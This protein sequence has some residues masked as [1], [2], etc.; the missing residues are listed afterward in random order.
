MKY[1][2]P[3]T[4]TARRGAFFTM[5]NEDAGRAIYTEAF[6]MRA[7]HKHG[8]FILILA[9]LFLLLGV[10]GALAENGQVSGIVWQDKT[11][12]GVIAGGETGL[13][14]AKVTLEI[15]DANG[16]PQV[17]VNATS[18]KSG[19]F[20]FT[21]LGAGEYRLR[22]E[23][24]KD[25]HFTL[26]GLDSAMLPA[27]GNVSYSPWFTLGENESRQMN[28]GAT[29]SS[30][31]VNLI[32]FEDENANG[33]RMQ[34]EPLLKGV[35]TEVL[36]E[37]QDETCL[38][39]SA[40]TDR[41]GQALIRDLSPGTYRVRVTFPDHF[42]AGPIGQKLN[43]FYNCILPSEDNATGLSEPFTLSV[44]ESMSMGA[45]MVRTGSLA[46]RAWF[47]ANFNGRW[48]GDESG[49][50]GAQVVLHAVESGFQRTAQ[51]D[52]KGDFL[53]Q[54][55]QPGDYL[56]QFLLPEGMIFTYP[57]QSL[58]SETAG[59]GTVNV[60]V[61]V[62]VTT[63]LGAVGAMD[64]AGLTLTLYG[65]LNLNGLRDPD[66]PALSG[67]AVTA[68]QG[69][70]IVE[71]AVTDENGA[72][73]F[74]ALR[75]GDTQ[76]EAAL[77]EG[78]LFRADEGGLFSVSGVQ[79]TAQAAVA[80]D[81]A[82]PDAQFEA[83]VIPAAAV[84]G[85]LFEDAVN[86][87]LFREDSRLLSGFTVQAV[88]QSG[89]V[90][91]EAVTDENGVYTLYPLP[92]DAY[93]VRFLLR[94]AYVASPFAADQE[95]DGNQI[96]VQTPAYGETAAFTLA[97]GEQK[98]GV[99]G[100]VFQA[101]LAEGYVLVDDAYADAGPGLSGVK[102]TLLSADG[103]PASDHSYG[104]TDENGYFFIKG[105]LPGTYS[106]AYQLPENGV[107]TDPAVKGT[108]YTGEAFQSESGS[109]IE[110]PA[111]KGMYTASVS[112]AI[113]HSAPEEA[114]LFTAL[115]T[116]RGH[117]VNQ[118][119]EIHANPDGS[120]A[121]SGLLPDTYT[122]TATLPQ[123]LAFGELEGSPFGRS[124]NRQQSAEITLAMGESREDICIQAVTPLSIFG[125]LYYDDDFSGLQDEEE[126]GAENRAVSLWENGEQIDACE[127]DES[128]GFFF[129]QVIPGTYEVR[130]VMDENEELEDIPDAIR[131]AGE[132]VLPI[133]IIR[134][135]SL[136][137]PVMRYASV[138]GQVWSLGSGEGVGGVTVTLLDSQ[139]G[140]LAEETSGSSGDFLFNHLMP[141][142]YALSAALPEG[143]LFARAQ[144]TSGRESFVQS[145]VDGSVTAIP[146]FVPTG[147]DLS[148]IDIG[149][150]TMGSIG[151]RAWLDVNGNG[152]QD[153]DEPSMPGIVI[154]L[155]QY[156]EFVASTTTD[157]Y[158]RYKLDGL[159][160]G[161]YEMRVT[162]HK[163]LKATV[164]QTDF[165][166]VGSILPES[167]E[168][169]V[170]VSKVTVPS[171][172][173]NLH[174]DLGFQLRKKNVYPAAMDTIPVKDWRPYSER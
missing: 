170:T 58:L 154:E 89:E 116:L 136:V 52:E 41:D 106:L 25:Y 75:G 1:G 3:L 168:L 112:G 171:G 82:E 174:C 119:Y 137:L 70:R 133:S 111:V 66:E 122:L 17:A 5:E 79:I 158:G 100:S 140:A 32:A 172:K 24:D 68:A 155:Y 83:A 55:L 142:T 29:K 126:Y 49:L 156:G 150:G 124:R 31:S 113:L 125:I 37:Y 47:D 2:G 110:A 18:S 159:Y 53:F 81:G 4:F 46:G 165:P 44:K 63:D 98:T 21:N 134:D 34:T 95:A 99:N 62:D 166:L 145:Q 94:D 10:Q 138:S 108:R 57:G 92:A 74:N 131:D 146:F 103:E 14:G 123:G 8:G 67:A 73:V 72:A 130:I 65:D 107:F 9:A 84:S 20:L 35:L 105:I 149:V 48:D 61:Q 38:I 80:L 101:G 7:M 164:Y 167:S 141:G 27:Q 42:T 50:T 28:A 78:W 109:H 71:K 163:E 152:M 144:D 97:P 13:A 54:A 93:A 88:S 64:A 60:Y 19:D 102:V 85:V 59:T 127:T 30:C 56:V 76:I 162:M 118:A 148:G 86:T 26:F 147:D 153:M 143:Y 117:T 132:V 120:F 69:G 169:T 128:G 45:G 90:T 121:F 36:F 39:A 173:A 11:A 151:D 139:G 33:G 51:P 77:P 157:V 114:G 43:T 23:L 6:S 96:Q 104:V 129:F 161:D 135:M 16:K 115:L 91:A 160:P 12:D 87:G 40:V 15:K 22:I